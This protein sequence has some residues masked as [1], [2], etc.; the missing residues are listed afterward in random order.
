V[1]DEPDS[2][3]PSYCPVEFN[4]MENNGLTPE[5]PHP[6]ATDA[7]LTQELEVNDSL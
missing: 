3:I 4:M 1:Q 2:Y 5:L 6:D 7:S